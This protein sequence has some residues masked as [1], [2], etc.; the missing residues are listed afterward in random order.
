MRFPPGFQFVIKYVSP[1]YLLTVFGLWCY[2]NL[3]DYVRN[4]GKG[5]V[6]LL[7]LGVIAAVLV[8]LLLLIGIA[9]KRWNAEE[10]GRL[11]LPDVSPGKEA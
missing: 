8:F 3:P 2:V 1:L 10:K 4:L 5:G 9:G 6:P 11:P 7:T